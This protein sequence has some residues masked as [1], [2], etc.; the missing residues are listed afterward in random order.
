METQKITKIFPIE[1]ILAE[2]NEAVSSG[3]YSRGYDS[4]IEQPRDQLYNPVYERIN[5][6]TKE[7]VKYLRGRR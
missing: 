4:L 5:N 2:C 7:L 3:N 6:S 1:E